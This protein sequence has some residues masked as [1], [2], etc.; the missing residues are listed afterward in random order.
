MTKSGQVWMTFLYDFWQFQKNHF[1]ICLS[2]GVYGNMNKG[3]YVHTHVWQ[4][5]YQNIIRKPLCGSRS[6]LIVLSLFFLFSVLALVF[7]V[8]SIVCGFLV[9]FFF[10]EAVDSII[11][12]VSILK[13]LNRSYLR[14]KLYAQNIWRALNNESTT[15]TYNPY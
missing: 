2:Y 3:V 1:V 8:G 6:N 4:Q 7:G 12:S 11:K 14:T 5:Y 15:V 13:I 10:R 9:V